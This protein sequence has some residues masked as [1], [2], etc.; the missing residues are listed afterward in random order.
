MEG[1]GPVDSGHVPCRHGTRMPSEA[2]FSQHISSPSRKES[3]SSEENFT[4]SE[5]GKKASE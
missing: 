2:D 1:D 3:V 5:A 4:V